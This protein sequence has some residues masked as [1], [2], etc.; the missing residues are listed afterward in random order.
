MVFKPGTLDPLRVSAWPKVLFF[1]SFLRHY[2]AQAGLK[3][4][5]LLP[6]PPKC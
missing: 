3:F 5:I 1:F 6:P 4:T 2:I